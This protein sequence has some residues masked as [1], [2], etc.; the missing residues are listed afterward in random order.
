[1]TRASHPTSRAFTLIELLLVLALLALAVGVVAPSLRG[2]SHGTR[3]R[4]HADEFVAMTQYA[5]TQSAT[6]ATVFRVTFD[7]RA[8][9]GAGAFELHQLVGNEF[10]ANTDEFDRPL[11]PPDGCRIELT[12]LTGKAINSIDFFPTGRGEP[13]RF[14]VFDDQLG[15]RV[16]VES[17]SPAEPF[18]VVPEGQPR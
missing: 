1:M 6:T 5:R 4:G 12:D 17:Q 9:N 16:T 13:A 14:V 7:P 2:F 18:K 3:L 8:N 15:R 10:S 11:L